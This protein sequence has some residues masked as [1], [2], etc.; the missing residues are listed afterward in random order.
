MNSPV[1]LPKGR[2][3]F[4]QFE[5]DVPSR[6][7]RKNGLRIRIQEQPAMILEA[8]LTRE[9]EVVSRE[10]LR[11]L[12]WPGDTFVE[13]E[14]CLN[15]AVAK[16]RQ[17]LSDSAEHPRYIETVAR[18]GYRFIG[19]VEPYLQPHTPQL[20][21]PALSSELVTNKDQSVPKTGNWVWQASVALGMLTFA[22]F[23]WFRPASVDVPPIVRFVIPA[24]VGMRIHPVS[25][26]SL[27]GRK[28]AFVAEG[29]LGQRSL[30]LRNLDS[31]TAVR[32]DHTGGAIAPFFSP[33]S[34]H[35]G[36][37]ADG[38][39]K[40]ISVSGGAP[41][42]L[43]NVYQPAGGTWNRDQVILFSHSGR[44]HKV[45]ATGGEPIELARPAVAA[46]EAQIDSWPHF[47]PD[48]NRFIVSTAIHNGHINPIRSEVLLGALDSR[49]RKVLLNAR[50]S[51]NVMPNGLLLF[52]REGSLVAQKLDL[53]RGKMAGQ[54]VTVAQD[55]NPSSGEIVVDVKQGLPVA[56]PPATFSSSAGGVL[57][58]HSSPPARKQLVWFDRDGKRLGKVG[59]PGDYM[60]MIVSPDEQYAALAVRNRSSFN[61]W[62]LWLL[63]LKTN[64]LSQLSFGVGRDADP[65][66]SP[67]SSRVVYGAYQAERGEQVDLMEI[68]LGE[69]SAK[70]I[71]SD[72]HS[73]KP[74][75]WSPD[76]SLLLVRRNEQVI[77]PL[78]M[79][80]NGKSVVLL[81]TPHIRHGFRFSPDGRWL[82]YVS[83]ESGAPEVFVSRYPD[84]S[85]TRQVSAGGGFAPVWRKD[86]REL[87]YMTRQGYIF[88]V[89]LSTGSR[90][91]TGPPRQ[92]FRTEAR[93]INMPQFA[94]SDDGQRF[95]VLEAL[96]SQ[97]ADERLVVITGLALP[98]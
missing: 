80:G 62:N 53:N 48:G 4:A 18:R 79:S 89:H 27:D 87:F 76:G 17:A 91:E 37:F 23:Y 55:L 15:T 7:L 49:E 54:M 26:V 85:E 10:E 43:C 72:G 90:L 88:S 21:R 67:D 28:L 14:R 82:T 81:S 58:F 93:H 20:V 94:A 38:K 95:L 92:M 83:S 39:L 71:H 84:M 8:L 36:F 63:L 64:V 3:R 46:G 51:A 59:E 44:L 77:F 32:I 96:P 30:W 13:F 6:Q 74:E 50:S 11:Q 5:L 33:D 16:L 42:T 60:Q 31:E 24:P 45:A 2:F 40:R 25:A 1:P 61:H 75:A 34:Q 56:V 57:A 29:E 12:L 70:R 98:Q 68:K 69:P 9:G 35:I 52:R 19:R 86:G 65:V 78:P 73:N 22:A 97:V 41:Q 47:L 66:W